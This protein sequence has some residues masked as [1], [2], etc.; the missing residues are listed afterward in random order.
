MRIRLLGDFEVSVGPRTIADASWRL[1]KA[2]GLIKILALAPQ[3]RLPRGRATELVWP[4]SDAKTASNNLRGALH[5]ARKALG[6]EG[7]EHLASEDG[8]LLLCPQGD[9]WVDTE[10]F[11]EAASTARRY[12]N[13]AAYRMAIDLYA[14]ELLPEDRFE[15][16][17]EEERADLRRLYLD[18]LTELAGLYREQ[19]EH[20]RA[21]EALQKVVAEEPTEEEAHAFLMR[22]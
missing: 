5:A 4:D 21:I 20:D 10:A 6:A 14:G 15:D 13:P 2:A 11:E 7:S 1:R 8:T 18:L 16:W 12:H 19:G 9:L 3:H 22:L 17:A